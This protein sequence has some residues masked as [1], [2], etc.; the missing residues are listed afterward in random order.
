MALN[1]RFVST[2]HSDAVSGKKFSAKEYADKYYDEMIVPAVMEKAQPAVALYAALQ[3]NY[4]A[5]GE[6]FG[7][8]DGAQSAWA[9][10]VTFT[11]VAGKVNDV[12]GQMPVTVDG[13]SGKPT[14]LV[15][16]GPPVMGPALRDVTG[17]I[18]FGMFTNQTEFQSVAVELNSKVRNEVLVNVKAAELEGKKVAVVGVFSG[19]DWHSKWLITPVKIEVAE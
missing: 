17:K 5:A 9:F 7:G 15:Q 8:R 4:E 6:K 2:E 10:P 1:T 19:R 12:N 11:G 16:T 13:L 18:T 14:L 3:S